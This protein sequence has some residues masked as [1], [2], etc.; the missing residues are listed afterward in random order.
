MI[1]D[2]IFFPNIVGSIFTDI[3]NCGMVNQP[4]HDRQLKVKTVSKIIWTTVLVPFIYSCDKSPQNEPTSEIQINPEAQQPLNDVAN[5]ATSRLESY[6]LKEG[7][8][9]KQLIGEVEYCA[10]VYTLSQSMAA[11]TVRRTSDQNTKQIM[12]Q[13]FESMSVKTKGVMQLLMMMT[14]GQPTMRVAEVVADIGL[15]GTGPFFAD[16][17]NAEQADKANELIASCD[18]LGEDMMKINKAL[19]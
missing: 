4:I 2:G 7:R 9:L 16:E 18:R 10:S 11:N 1:P 19:N 13:M 8:T 6:L 12:L 15:Q 14:E 5:N 17:L 3:N